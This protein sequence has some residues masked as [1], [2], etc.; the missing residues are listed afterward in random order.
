LISKLVPLHQNGNTY[1]QFEEPVDQT[2]FVHF[3]KRI[4]IQ[5]LQGTKDHSRGRY[6]G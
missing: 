2:E 4:G 6:R 5:M 3:R 1:S